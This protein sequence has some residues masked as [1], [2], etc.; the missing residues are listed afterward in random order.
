M[1]PVSLSLRRR[2]GLDTNSLFVGVDEIARG[3]SACAVFLWYP[4]YWIC[5]NQS[6][7]FACR[8]S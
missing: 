6:K 7:S 8:F 2:H 5:Y 4:L 1:M 3:F